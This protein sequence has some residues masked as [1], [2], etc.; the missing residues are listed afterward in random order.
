[1][2]LQNAANRFSWRIGIILWVD[3]QDLHEN[4]VLVDHF[5]DTIGEGSSAIWS[6]QYYIKSY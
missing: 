1:M 4:I 6:G 5:A 3:R 2:Y